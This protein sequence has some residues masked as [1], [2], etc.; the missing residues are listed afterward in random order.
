ME[1]NSDFSVFC[2]FSMNLVVFSTP[3]QM[4]VISRILIRFPKFEMLREAEMAF[5]PFSARKQNTAP[6]FQKAKI[7]DGP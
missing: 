1:S 7:T 5:S 2:C 6:I 4:L 3:T